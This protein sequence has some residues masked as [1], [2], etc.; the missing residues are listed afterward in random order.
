VKPA[1]DDHLVLRRDDVEPLRAG[2]PDP[3][4]LL[5]FCLFEIFQGQALCEYLSGRQEGRHAGMLFVLRSE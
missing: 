1:G 2:F 3:A 5:R 4:S